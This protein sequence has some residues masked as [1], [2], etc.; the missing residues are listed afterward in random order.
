MYNLTEQSEWSKEGRGHDLIIKF[1]TAKHYSTI[2][3]PSIPATLAS[4]VHVHSYT[5]ELDNISQYESIQ[6]SLTYTCTAHVYII[7]TTKLS[8][9]TV[10]SYTHIHVHTVYISYPAKH[11]RTSIP[12]HKLDKGIYMCTTYAGCNRVQQGRG[13]DPTIRLHVYTQIMWSP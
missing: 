10:H 2:R 12:M 13:H 1:Q 6:T 7:C 8:R 9:C 4:T 3:Q 5:Q 11:E